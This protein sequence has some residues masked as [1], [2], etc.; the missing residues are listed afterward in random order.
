MLLSA[1]SDS[2]AE[3]ITLRDDD[4]SR[5][6]F[7]LPTG[8]EAAEPPPL[9]EGRVLAVYTNHGQKLIIA[10]L[11]GNTEGAYDNKAA[12]FSGLET[13]VRNENEGW[14]RLSGN[15]RR[16]G[17]K[18]KLPAYDLWYRAGGALHGMR[19]IFT[20]SDAVIL[21][22]ET[23]GAERAARRLVESFGPPL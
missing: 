5:W 9:A 23:Q 3:F 16:L 19:F 7:M 2:H 14:R 6:Q 20:R 17:S 4:D 22:L 13:G 12:F 18:R 8:W 11:R 10:R 15:L 21:H 1:A